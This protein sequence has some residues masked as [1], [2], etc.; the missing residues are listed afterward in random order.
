[1]NSENFDSLEALND[2]S[3]DYIFNRQKLDGHRRL[4]ICE[5]N[6]DPS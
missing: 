5:D 1:M 4:S 6:E 2:N 3:L